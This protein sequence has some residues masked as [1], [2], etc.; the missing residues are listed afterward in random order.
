[1]LEIIFFIAL[2]AGLGALF[3][4]LKGARIAVSAVLTLSV[5]CVVTVLGYREY[6]EY[7]EVQESIHQ[8]Q[9]EQYL[10]SLPKCKDPYEEFRQT[11][12]QETC[13]GYIDNTQN[14]PK[15]VTLDK[16]PYYA[17]PK[18]QNAKTNHA[19]VRTKI[20]IHKF[21]WYDPDTSW[22]TVCSSLIGTLK[23]GDNV[24]LLSDPVRSVQ[25]VDIREI[26]FNRWTGWVNEDCLVNT[27][28]SDAERK[29]V[30]GTNYAER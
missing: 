30:D 21:C 7:K 27:Y 29:K 6:K 3:G 5:L 16:A 25:G 23:K 11:K 28:I 13:H 14:I 15:S 20:E 9:Q 10:N 19:F 8:E 12:G 26:K 17:A 1:M 22:N 18:L 4:G 24:L 2:V